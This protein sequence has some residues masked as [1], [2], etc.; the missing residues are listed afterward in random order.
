MMFL[1]FTV[2]IA[3]GETKPIAV[4]DWIANYDPPLKPREYSLL[5]FRAQFESTSDGGKYKKWITETSP[6]Q[7]YDG[8][9]IDC[10]TKV[11]PSNSSGPYLEMTAAEFITELR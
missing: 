10:L 4:E 8:L 9:G 7:C 3:L 11:K 6:L 1:I 5:E 2:I